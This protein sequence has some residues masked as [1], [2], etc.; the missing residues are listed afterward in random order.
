MALDLFR[1]IQGV[2]VETSSGSSNAS[3]LV[4]SGAPGGDASYQ[5][6]ASIGS[7]YLRT[8]ANN[9][10][11]NLQVYFKYATNNN[12][13]DWKLAADKAYVD[14]AIQGLSWRPPVVVLDATSYASSTNFP[15]GGVIDGVTL[16]NGSRVLFTN[17]TASG[18]S[19]VWVWNGSTWTEDT[20]AAANG[21]AIYVESGSNAE[22]QWVYNGTTWVLFVSVSGNQE[23]G[24]IR[25]YIGKPS[26]G[27]V[28]PTYSSVTNI[29]QSTNLTSA[30][31]QLDAAIGSRTAYTQQNYVTDGQTVAASINSLDV[32]VGTLA[33]QE[34]VTTASNVTAT[35]LTTID[36][37]ALTVASEAE[38]MI[39]VRETA[40]PANIRGIKVMAINDGSAN[41]DYNQFSILKLGASVAGFGAS[42][43]ISGGNMVLQ[44]TATNNVDYVVKRIAY[45]HFY[46]SVSQPPM[47]LM[48]M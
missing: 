5:D 48:Y 15:T 3:L 9:T 47:A 44:I 16:T 13:A 1:V 12:A 17:V 31:G 38:W 36:T 20:H 29:T 41:V 4:G 21:D 7:I 42:V 28:N 43:S 35:S 37:L 18:Q 25:S 34:L 10:A 14:A 26:A 23:F 33:A 19:N 45:S 8:D 39:Q 6:A 11:S 30:I 46:N 27:S 40:T 32:E 22:T 24:Y 2:N